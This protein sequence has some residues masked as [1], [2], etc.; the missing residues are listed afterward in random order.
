MS[1]VI[2]H[3]NS[4]KITCPDPIFYRPDASFHGTST[5]VTCAKSSDSYILPASPL[6]P[7]FWPDSEQSRHPQPT[8]SRDFI[9]LDL[10]NKLIQTAVEHRPSAASSGSSSLLRQFFASLAIKS[11]F[12]KPPASTFIIGK[13][14]DHRRHVHRC[15]YKLR[16]GHRPRSA[17]SASDGV[18]DFLLLLHP[19]RRSAQ[20]KCLSRMSRHA[21][22]PACSKP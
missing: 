20:H 12:P 2:L 22:S 4:N 14:V 18:E 15:W 11:F 1:I 6:L 10:G 7:I 21:G 9:Q 16:A 3:M 13:Y 19:L 5:K 8:D 17:R